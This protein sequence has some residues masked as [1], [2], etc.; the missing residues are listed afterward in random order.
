VS[1]SRRASAVEAVVNV[2]VG[3]AVSVILTMALF[4]TTVQTGALVAAIFAAVSFA[5]AYLI[6]RA[7]A[8]LNEKGRPEGR[9]LE[10]RSR[11]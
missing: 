9:P 11:N 5:R 8:W 10:V 2:A 7:F 3:Y 1:Q 4:G 6:R